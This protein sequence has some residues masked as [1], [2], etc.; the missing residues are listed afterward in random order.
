MFPPQSMTHLLGDVVAATGK[1]QLRMAETEKYSARDLLF[2]MAASRPPIRART[3]TW[4][5]T[6]G[7]DLRFAN[8]K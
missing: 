5:L 6:Q 1:R 2:S 3:A 7:G 8:R 4:F